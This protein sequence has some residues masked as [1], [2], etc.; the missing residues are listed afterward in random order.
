[1]YEEGRA[2][3]RVQGLTKSF[4]GVRA[5]DGL[6]LHVPRG[7][8]YGLVGPNGAGKST[9]IR[10]LA[11]IYRQDK[12]EVLIDGAPV[13][14]DPS[15]KARLAYIPDEI[16]Y[17]PQASIRDTMR[18]YRAVYPRFSPERF[19]ALGRAFDLDTRRSMRKLSKGSRSRPPSGSALPCSRRS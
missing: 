13:F 4:E 7:A 17:Y 2:M 3:I 11:G 14:D 5:L 16:F 10:H 9:L 8:V 1:M 18:L 6:D 15:V 12:G 19:E